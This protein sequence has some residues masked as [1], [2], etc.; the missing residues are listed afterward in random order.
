MTAFRIL[1]I[2]FFLDFLGYTTLVGIHHGWNLFA[3]VFSDLAAITWSG[4]FNL[5][6][7]GFLTL[8]G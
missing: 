2:L 4:Q 1:L 3:I 6:F 5:D 7:M 8:S